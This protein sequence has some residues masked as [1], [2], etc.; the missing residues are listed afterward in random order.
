MDNSKAYL[1]CNMKKGIKWFLG[2]VIGLV[3]VAALAV[4][5]FMV[6]NRWHETGRMMGNRSYQFQ[7]TDR[8]RSWR[9]VP[10][11]EDS[12]NERPQGQMP[13][14]SFWGVSISRFGIFRP[15]QMIFGC[16]IALGLLVLLVLGVIY[17]F[18]G[19]RR[20][21]QPAVPPAGVTPLVATPPAPAPVQNTEYVCPHCAK[22]VQK[23]W[24]HCPN[25]GGP[26]PEQADNPVPPA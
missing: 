4:A 15:L 2:I 7:G 25:C 21:Q 3:I 24:R 17:L 20:L 10:G 8:S 6:V 22:P 14:R 11:Q 1:E 16:F 13:M 12:W 23:D 5:G 18:G 26:L 19:R 9:D